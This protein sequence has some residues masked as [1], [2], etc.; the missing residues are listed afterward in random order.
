MPKKPFKGTIKLDVR[1]SV[2]DWEPYLPAKAPAGCT[3]HPVRPVRR[4][5]PGRV[6][7]LRRRHQHA[8]APEAG[9]SRPALFAVAHDGAV[10]ADALHAPDRT[11]PSPERHGGDHRGREWIPRRERAHPAGVRDDA[12]DPP[13]QRLEHLLARQGS[14]RAGA[15]H[16]LGRDAQAVA[17]AAGLRSLLR[18]PRRRDQ[19]VVPGPRR[20][21]QVHRPAV[22]PGR[23][24]SPLQGSG[25]P[26]AP[27]APRP[28]RHQPVAALVH[29]VLPGRQPCAAPLPAGVHR[30][31]QGQV[32]RGL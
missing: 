32:R 27:H 14:Q 19:P 25:R 10:L 17:A 30:Q 5:R 8:D 26:G 2:A 23:G 15:G 29:V 13:G 4:H 16:R 3:E 1:D 12:A 9:R 24:V 31:V 22:Q 6:V 7:A 28:P 20:R 18:L 11:Q 21:Q